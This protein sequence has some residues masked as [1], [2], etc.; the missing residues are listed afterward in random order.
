MKKYFK[1]L[2]LTLFVISIINFPVLASSINEKSAI[3]KEIQLLLNSEDPLDHIEAV[4]LMESIDEKV[5]IK[6]FDFG[7]LINEL[8]EAERKLAED[9]LIKDIE[10]LSNFDK[11][12]LEEIGCLDEQIN[13]IKNFDGTLE[14]AILASPTLSVYGGFTDYKKSNSLTTAKMVSVFQWSGR[15]ASLNGKKDIFANAWTSP[16]WEISEKAYVNYN[17]YDSSEVYKTYPNVIPSSTNGSYITFNKFKSGH[18]LYAGSI[19]TQLSAKSF[20]PNVGG[21]C[22]YGKS[23]TSVTPSASISGSGLGVGISF[24]KN[25]ITV[26][27]KRYQAY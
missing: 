24:S 5:Y 17:K 1:I 16:M 25:V 22:S 9:T 19:I 2:T 7:E 10:T 8:P 20:E 27:S 21:F 15:Y 4:K 14:S 11:D 26:G 13:A 3:E 18:H 23:T 6:T 12:A